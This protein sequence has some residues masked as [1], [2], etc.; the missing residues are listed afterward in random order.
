[1]KESLWTG[2]KNGGEWNKMVFKIEIVDPDFLEIHPIGYFWDQQGNT[3]GREIYA[4]VDAAREFLRQLIRSGYKRLL[5][6]CSELEFYDGPWL[7]FFDIPHMEAEK[8]GGRVV[9]MNVHAQYSA[10]FEGD[11]LYFQDDRKEAIDLL[12]VEEAE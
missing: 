10:M 5:I 4:R 11:G 9:W 6:D 7:A 3:T 8:A 2:P 12:S 1:M